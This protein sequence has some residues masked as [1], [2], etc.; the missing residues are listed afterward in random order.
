M[1][2]RQQHRHSRRSGVH[3]DARSCLSLAQADP[4]RKI[5]ARSAPDK[6]APATNLSLPFGLKRGFS[7]AGHAPPTGRCPSV[8]MGDIA[9][10]TL[11]KPAQRPARPEFSSGPCAKRP[12]LDPRKSQKRRPG[13]LAPLEAGQGAPEGRH[14]P[15]ARSAGSARR[16][17]DRHR[18]RLGHRRRR[19]GDVVDAGRPPGATDGLRVLRQG[20]GHG[21]HQAAEAA[22]RRGARRARTASCPTPPRSIRPRTWSSPGTAPPRAS[23]F[24]TPTSSRPTVKA[25][26]SAT[27]PAPPS[28]RTW[29]GPSSMS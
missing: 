11:A 14:R 2:S 3:P 22:E 7:P 12:R 1:R 17:P 21:R 15:D 28:P 10:T 13:S 27:P 24:R 16:L 9:M 23:A 25:S 26:P 5:I 29:T 6:S 8:R 20:L 18:R 4:S 19:N